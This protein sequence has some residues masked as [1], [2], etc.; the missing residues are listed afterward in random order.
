M[1]PERHDIRLLKGRED[2]RARISDGINQLDCGESF[3]EVTVFAEVE[4]EISRIES[5][6]FQ[7]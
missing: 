5:L 2:L 7:G 4:A 3:D 6:G 1:V